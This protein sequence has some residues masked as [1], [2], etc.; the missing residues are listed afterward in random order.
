MSDR[1]WDQEPRE[2]PSSTHD[3]P[4][5]EHINKSTIIPDLEMTDSAQSRFFSTSHLLVLLLKELDPQTLLLSQRVARL[6]KET[7]VR[8]NE[9]QEKLFF[10]AID[11]TTDDLESDATPNPLLAAAF[12]RYFTKDVI[13]NDDELLTIGIENYYEQIEN[14]HEAFRYPCA[15]WQHMLPQQPPEPVIVI[16]EVGFMPTRMISIKGR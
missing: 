1:L 6:W 5:T 2:C 11:G 7:I 16:A 15:S 14:S 12:P 10:K 13:S 8:S 4:P 9:L 3:L